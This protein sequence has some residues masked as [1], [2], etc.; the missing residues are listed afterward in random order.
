MKSEDERIKSHREAVKK[1][2][3]ANVYQFKCSF[4]K[5]TDKALIDHLTAQPNKQ[6]YVKSLI[7]KD[8][9]RGQK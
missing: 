9:E 1:H 7:L 8:M 2:N 6:G 3:A 4:N 5:N